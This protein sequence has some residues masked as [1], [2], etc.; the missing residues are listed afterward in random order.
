MLTTVN[1][2][3]FSPVQAMDYA[4]Y[5]EWVRELAGN[6]ATSDADAS[7]SHIQYTHL[8][9]RRIA[10]LNKTLRVEEGLFANLH[11][12]PAMEWMVLSESWCGDAAQNLP[13][14]NIVAEHLHIPLT[15]VPRD[16]NPEIMEAFL[17][18]GSRAIPKLIMFD[19]ASGDVLATWGPRPAPAQQLVMDAKAQQVPS[20]TYNLALQQWYNTDKSL[21]LQKELAALLKGLI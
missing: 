14:I 3:Q 19:R 9:E 2:Q 15:I 18:N 13:A 10:R 4:A 16:E 17:T 8:N 12:L 1:Q 5:F 21:T 6:K 20:E 11:A 7:E